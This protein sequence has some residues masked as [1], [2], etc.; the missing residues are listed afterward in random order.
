MAYGPLCARAA[1]ALEMLK[2]GGKITDGAS[3]AQLAKDPAAFAKQVHT[4]DV[5]PAVA[6]C[7]CAAVF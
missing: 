1:G 7:A 3:C 6:A 4:E 5:P 2:D